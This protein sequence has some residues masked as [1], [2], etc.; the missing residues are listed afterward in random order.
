M[1]LKVDAIVRKEHIQAVQ[2]ESH[3]DAFFTPSA[4][5]KLSGIAYEENGQFLIDD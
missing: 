4:Y 3:F 1:L 5:A 2:I